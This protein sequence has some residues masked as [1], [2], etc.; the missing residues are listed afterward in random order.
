MRP[1]LPFLLATG[2][3][4]EAA[5]AGDVESLPVLGKPYRAAELVEAVAGLLARRRVQPG[6]A[7][8]SISE[9]ER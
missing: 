3:A 4:A 6:A 1:G 5:M 2:Y 8:I 9:N 7:E